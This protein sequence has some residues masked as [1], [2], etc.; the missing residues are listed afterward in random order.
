M[1][2]CISA[3]VRGLS[4]SRARLR[5]QQRWYL[6]ASVLSLSKPLWS[7]ADWGADPQMT[8]CLW[9]LL[10]SNVRVEATAKHVFY[11]FE[12]R[13]CVCCSKFLIHCHCPTD[14]GSDFP[15]ACELYRNCTGILHRMLERF[16]ELQVSV[17]QPKR[18]ENVFH[19]TRLSDWLK[20]TKIA[21]NLWSS[22]SQHWNNKLLRCR[23]FRY[24][25]L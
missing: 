4:L 10:H 8:Q 6:R 15:L 9:L 3:A 2:N 20:S 18:G 5:W 23:F 25:L 12:K 22:H 11:F 16:R 17:K 14:V 24:T 7:S 13:P 21:L 1:W 19:L